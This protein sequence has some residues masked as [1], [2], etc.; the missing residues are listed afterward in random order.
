MEK[1]LG[2]L[3]VEYWY[4][5]FVVLGV[6]GIIAAVT[7]DLKGIANS[8]ALLLSGGVFFVGMG[9]WVNHPLRT[10]IISGAIIRRHP[11][12]SSLLGIAFDIVGL[13]LVGIELYKMAVAA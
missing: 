9:E 12:S 7:L 13:T 5:V 6:A 10:G 4:H 11:R 8:H 3:K 2:W 1:A